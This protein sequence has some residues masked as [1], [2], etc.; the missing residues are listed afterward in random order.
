MAAALVV[1]GGCAVFAAAAAV[2]AVVLARSSSDDS[3][4]R[5]TDGTRRR[6]N[7]GGGSY[8]EQHPRSIPEFEIKAKNVMTPLTWSV[9]SYYAGDGCTLRSGR[10]AFDSIRLLPRVL[11]LTNK[12]KVDTSLELFGDTLRLPVLI[13][14]SSHHAMYCNDGEVATAKGAGSAGAGYCYNWMLAD[15][16]HSK[17]VAEIL[18]I[19]K[20]KEMIEKVLRMS[21]K[22]NYSAIIL[23]V[24]NPI[25]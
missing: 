23:Y 10:A 24:Q 5:S 1:V 22:Q 9:C 11:K 3:S 6:S 8:D 20:P 18:Y 25:V 15:M 14:P 21:N 12:D 17:V 16:H 13:A 2:G 7:G 19:D 4:S